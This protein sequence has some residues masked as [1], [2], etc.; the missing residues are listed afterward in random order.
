MVKLEL[1]LTNIY[2]MLGTVSANPNITSEY[3]ASLAPNAEK[4]KEEIER[5]GLQEYEE[6]QKTVFLRDTDGT[7]VI[8]EHM[9]RGFLKNAAQAMNQVSG[10]KT[11]SLKAHTKAITRSIFIKERFIRINVDPKE[12][13][14]NQRPLRISNG[15]GS[16][17]ER[18]ALAYSEEIPAG[19]TMRFTM[20]VLEESLLP[21][22]KEWLDYGVF[23]GLGQWRNASYGK[24][25]WTAINEVKGLPIDEA[26][27]AIIR[28]ALSQENIGN[29][30]V[31]KDSAYVNI[32]KKSI[33]VK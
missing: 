10:S 29:P 2:P 15:P 16:G 22:V 4:K 24:F 28:N 18:V 19:K 30:K 1:E 27:E 20:Y 5:I 13:K 21:Y 25:V 7:P 32:D 12:I 11:K 31:D 6:K 23:C 26:R 8:S 33:L 14:T 9:I 17:S 3:I